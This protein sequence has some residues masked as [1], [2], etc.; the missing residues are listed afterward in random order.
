M[1]HKFSPVVHKSIFYLRRFGYA[2]SLTREDVKLYNF[3]GTKIPIK[4]KI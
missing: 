4:S 1:N 2:I 3:E